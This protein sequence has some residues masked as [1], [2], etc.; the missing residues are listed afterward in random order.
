MFEFLISGETKKKN[1]KIFRFNTREPLNFGTEQIHFRNDAPW[2]LLRCLFRFLKDFWRIPTR[3]VLL[4]VSFEITAVCSN[5]IK[6]SQCLLQPN[7]PA[8]YLIVVL[9]LACNYSRNLTLMGLV[10]SSDFTSTMKSLRNDQKK[11]QSVAIRS[12][13]RSMEKKL[14]CELWRLTK[15]SKSGFWSLHF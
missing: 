7:L 2:A 10:W 4:F 3:L 11:N 9:Y 8:I 6:N 15:M 12:E 13:L 14:R 5:K 1:Y